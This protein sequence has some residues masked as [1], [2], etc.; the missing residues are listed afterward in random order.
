MPH[1]QNWMVSQVSTDN[2]KAIKLHTRQHLN[3]PTITSPGSKHFRQCHQMSMMA[4]PRIYATMHTVHTNCTHN[5]LTCSVA[6]YVA[7]ELKGGISVTQCSFGL[8]SYH[9]TKILVVCVHN[10]CTL[11]CICI[12]MSKCNQGE[13]DTIGE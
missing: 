10:L 2:D 3:N 6:L 8:M 11:Y 13:G 1:L 7:M 9:Y 5:T 4:H 12:M